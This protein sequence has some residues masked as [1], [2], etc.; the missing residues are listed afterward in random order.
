MRN[1]GDAYGQLVGEVVH[2][3]TRDLRPTWVKQ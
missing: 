3:V 1:P 2:N